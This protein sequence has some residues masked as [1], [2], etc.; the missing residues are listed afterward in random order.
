MDLKK[1]LVLCAILLSGFFLPV[2]SQQVAKSLPK[3]KHG[4]IIIAHRGSHLNKPENTIA[5]IEEAIVFGAD[6]VEID[7]RT[8]HDGQLVLLHNDRVD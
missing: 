4:F 8:T 6:Y 3:S 7:L 1:N 5:A 2:F